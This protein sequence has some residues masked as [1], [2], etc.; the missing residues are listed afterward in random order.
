MSDHAA[1]YLNQWNSGRAALYLNSRGTATDVPARQ[2]ERPRSTIPVVHVQSATT[3]EKEPRDVAEASTQTSNTPNSVIEGANDA[4]VVMGCRALEMA[5]GK[6]PRSSEL[7]TPE[8]DIRVAVKSTDAEKHPR[9]EK[10][11]EGKTSKEHKASDDI[12]VVDARKRGTKDK[13]PDDEDDM[14]ITTWKKLDSEKTMENDPVTSAETK[15]P[16]L[17][18]ILKRGVAYVKKP[19]PKALRGKIPRTLKHPP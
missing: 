3:G 12:D 13:H 19:E 6:E 17:H 4:D 2:P 18:R 8:D 7:Q 14:E 10:S 15:K 9:S 5:E 1:A 16:I 11:D